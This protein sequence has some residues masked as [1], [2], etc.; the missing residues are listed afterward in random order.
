[1]F[2]SYTYLNTLNKLAAWEKSEQKLLW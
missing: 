1:M 2:T